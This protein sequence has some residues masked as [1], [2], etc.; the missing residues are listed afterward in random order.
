MFRFTCSPQFC[1]TRTAMASAVVA[2]LV[3]G[4]CSGENS[5]A[6]AKAKRRAAAHL[7]EVVSA[8]M[9]NLRL[10]ADREG[11]LRALREV[12]V[13]NQ[14]EGRI[15]R[16]VRREGDRIHKGTVLI[17]LEDALLRAEHDKAMAS[18]KQEELNVQRLTTL[19]G[20]K[21]VSDDTL[22]RAQ[23]A[24]AVAAAQERVLRARLGYMTLRA[25]FDGTVAAVLIKDGDV[26]PKH[27]HLM[28]VVD[29]SSLVTD[30][31]VSELVLT[32]LKLGDRADVR[33]DALG[34]RVF[35]GEITRVYP[36]VD[37]KTR[38][39]QIEVTLAPVPE[40]ARPGLFCRVSLFSD[41]TE[42]LVIP[43]AALRRDA[44]G[45]YVFVYVP[46]EKGD[47]IGK[48]RRADIHTGT[49]V[50]DRIEVRDGLQRGE[51]VVAKGF[52]GLNAGMT[53]RAV[54]LP[55]QPSEKPANK[56][57]KGGDA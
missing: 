24:L 48:V 1:A 44:K 54:N 31:Q 53:V 35:V 39:G 43:Q 26:A 32:R 34:D 13:F 30:V 6:K 20:K 57:K 36:A 49:R 11:T 8:A 29:P 42:Q 41:G 28:T 33:I 10:S 50:A 12:K 37:P 4:G 52:L 40:G 23:T 25:P 5:D 3:L 15:T 21:L 17:R 51:A 22:S 7:V 46:D 9:E 14:E 2:I 45:E 18:L 27:T 47:G 19:H 55:G 38:R 16:V 56:K